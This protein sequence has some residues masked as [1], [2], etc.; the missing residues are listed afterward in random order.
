MPRAATIASTAGACSSADTGDPQV[1]AGSVVLEREERTALALDAKR[2]MDQCVVHVVA[3][4]DRHRAGATPRDAG[5]APD[6]GVALAPAPEAVAVER[7]RR[8]GER[9]RSGGLGPW[10]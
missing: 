2:L 5:A 9:A 4:D 7:A 8:S 1:P 6:L 3:E 10:A